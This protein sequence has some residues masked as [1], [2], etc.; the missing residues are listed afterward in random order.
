M[1]PTRNLLLMIL[2]GA[3]AAVSAPSIQAQSSSRVELPPPPN[4]A[5]IQTTTPLEVLQQESWSIR[6][7]LLDDYRSNDLFGQM[8]AANSKIRGTA[9]RFGENLDGVNLKEEGPKLELMIQDLENM[10]EE[11]NFRASK[12]SNPQ[13]A[14]HLGRMIAALEEFKI[15]RQ[16]GAAAS[17]TSAPPINNLP[18]DNQVRQGPEYPLALPAMTEDPGSIAGALPEQPM[19]LSPPTGGLQI[20]EESV[21]ESGPLPLEAFELPGLDAPSPQSGERVF[22]PGIESGQV[23]VLPLPAGVE[24]PRPGLQPAL[25]APVPQPPFRGQVS[26]PFA[27][28]QLADQLRAQRRAQLLRQLQQIPIQFEIYSTG[29]SYRSGYRGYVPTGSY[30][31]GRSYSRGY[32]GGSRGGGGYCPTTGRRW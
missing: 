16:P 8:I 10:I 11:A 12:S 18:A 19:V 25:R 30:G 24:A 1:N 22:K 13:L 17:T 28:Q 27:Q 6:Q 7:M 20:V 2:I 23:E 31:G 3:A 21:I 15:S 9:R 32:G 5:A 14:G 29:P 26:D 4:T